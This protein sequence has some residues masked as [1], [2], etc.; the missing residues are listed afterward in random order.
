MRSGNVQ[1]ACVI[2]WPIKHSRSPLIHGYWLKLHA[3][4][5]TYD[6]RAVRPEDLSTFLDGLI[7]EGLAGCNVTIPHKESV[8]RSVHVTDPLA[9]RLQAVNTVYVDDGRLCGINTDGEGFLKH[10][11]DSNPLWDASS[12]PAVVFGAGGAARAIIATLV[13]AG[14]P[15]VRLTN[16]TLARAQVIAEDFPGRVTAHDW[17]QRDAIL[18]DATL[19]VNTTSLGMSD[20][21]PL[22]V[23]LANLPASATVY[24]IVYVPL[25]TPL[26]SQAAARGNPTVDGLGMLLHQAVP[27]F[28]RWFGVR[29]EVTPQLRQLIVAD[30]EAK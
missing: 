8:F 10:L 23:S 4:D 26:L 3:I 20:A 19:L 16:R 15:Q 7:A 18:D 2:G 11:N 27:G 13:A 5:G 17:D 24:D 14:V 25:V 6:K 1:R 21:D 30:L 22:I 12:G 28:E 9:Q 29:P